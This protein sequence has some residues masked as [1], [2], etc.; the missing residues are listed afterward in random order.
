[1]T[2]PLWVS[3]NDLRTM[4]RIV[5]APD[6]DED[7]EALPWSTLDALARLIPCVGLAFNGMDVQQQHHYFGQCTDAGES[8]ESDESEEQRLEE[9]FWKHYSDSH[10]S[11]PER[12]GDYRSVTMSTDFCSMREYRQTPMYLDYMKP[13]GIDHEIMATIPDG[14]SRQLRLIIFRGRTDPDFTERDRALIMLLRPHLRDAHLDVLRRRSGIPALTARQWEFLRLVEQGLGNRQIARRL[15]VSENTVR[16]HL[17]N[18]FARLEVSNRTAAV[19]RAF[20]ARTV[21]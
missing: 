7:G 5:K 13:A 15:G 9:I 8:D 12:T 1:V 11:H 4:L 14:G 10:C 2:T 6:L 16:K 3:E 19:A 20:P 21:P 17:E 18:I